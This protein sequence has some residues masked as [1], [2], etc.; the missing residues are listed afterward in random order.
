MCASHLVS[1]TER[2]HFP[3]RYY[4]F[5]YLSFIF[6]FFIFF[7]FLL[8]SVWSCLLQA[9][10]AKWRFFTKKNVCGVRCTHGVPEIR[11]SLP[12]FTSALKNKNSE[13]L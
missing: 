6:L 4:Y 13:L 10:A 12:T 8:V 1:K 2:T 3:F 7:F 9:Q 5:I 11:G